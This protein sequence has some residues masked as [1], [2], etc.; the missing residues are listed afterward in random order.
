M[1]DPQIVRMDRNRTNPN[2]NANEPV[3]ANAAQEDL[4][5]FWFRRLVSIPSRYQ[6]RELFCGTGCGRLTVRR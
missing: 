4:V 6:H 2:G 5:P 1:L 3:T